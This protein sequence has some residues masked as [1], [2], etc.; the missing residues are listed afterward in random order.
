MVSNFET[1]HEMKQWVSWQC[2]SRIWD[3]INFLTLLLF[4]LTALST[5]SFCLLNS[6]NINVSLSSFG[7][8][9]Q[10]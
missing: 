8:Q 9:L 6:H 10:N 4:I 2:G 3:N 5:M 7:L 1:V